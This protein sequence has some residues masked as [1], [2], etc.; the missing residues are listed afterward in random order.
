MRISRPCYDKPWRCP[1]WAGGGARFA[2]RHRCS[3]GS[4]AAGW[5]DRRTP[6]WRVNRCPRCGVYVL[7]YVVRWFDWRWWD[8]RVRDAVRAF[9][10]RI[11]DA[12]RRYRG[13]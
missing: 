2:R 13:L 5:A 7:P 9:R 12:V 6:Q 10:W 1:G 3:G 11:E 8:W 4:L